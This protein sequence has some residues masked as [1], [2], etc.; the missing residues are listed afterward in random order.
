MK[1]LLRV[2]QQ[3]LI[4]EQKHRQDAGKTERHCNG[5]A[6]KEQ[7]EQSREQE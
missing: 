2:R 5:R 3:G 1:E 7:D 4:A 6:D